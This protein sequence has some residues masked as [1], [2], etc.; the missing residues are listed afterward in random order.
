M[1]HPYDE[2]N[3]RTK[4]DYHEVPR[5]RDH[6]QIPICP[7]CGKLVYTSP[8]PKTWGIEWNS[9]FYHRR[10]VRLIAEAAKRIEECEEDCE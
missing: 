10:C 4:I 3:D 9:N 1:K 5:L 7:L 2:Y 6:R 8:N